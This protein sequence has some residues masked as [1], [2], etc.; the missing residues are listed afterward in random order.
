MDT[1]I[2]NEHF[3]LT[4]T[5]FPIIINSNPKKIIHEDTDL[6]SN[7]GTRCGNRGHS[8]SKQLQKCYSGGGNYFVVLGEVLERVMYTK[9]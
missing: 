4:K 1:R 3:F 6:I 8:P 5:S 2:P 7:R 9:R